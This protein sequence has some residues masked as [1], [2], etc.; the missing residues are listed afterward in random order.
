MGQMTATTTVHRDVS[1]PTVR[2]STS[3]I[4][5]RNV[6]EDA[7]HE[8]GPGEYARHPLRRPR[9]SLTCTLSAPSS[10]CASPLLVALAEAATRGDSRRSCCRTP[11]EF[12]G[13]TQWRRGS[14][15]I[16]GDS[17]HSCCRTP[18]RRQIA[19][20]TQGVHS[21]ACDTAAAT[22]NMQCVSLYQPQKEAA[23]QPLPLNQDPETAS[24]LSPPL[25]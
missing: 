15:G 9:P 10:C 8:T 12:A 20:Y 18:N 5:P 7:H 3:I 19:E 24:C 25:P 1:I 21:K 22:L 2:R 23:M 17:R 11:C 14:Q 13:R 16:R 6:T 4:S